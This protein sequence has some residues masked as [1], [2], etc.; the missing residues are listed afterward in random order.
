M[1]GTRGGPHGILNHPS[2]GGRVLVLT[3]R[4]IGDAVT[5]HMVA[6]VKLREP[7]LSAC[8]YECAA[9]SPQCGQMTKYRCSFPGSCN[10]A[11]ILRCIA[12]RLIVTTVDY[13]VWGGR[14]AVKGCWTHFCRPRLSECASVASQCPD[15]SASLVF[16]VGMMRC[17]QRVEKFEWPRSARF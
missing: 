11:C 9:P 15:A 13:S 1:V 16:F 10:L 17:L 8:A 7:V 3:L 6:Q 5:M 4:R 14:I 12:R 2:V